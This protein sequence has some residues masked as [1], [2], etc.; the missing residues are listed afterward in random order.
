MKI[1]EGEVDLLRG[2]RYVLFYFIFEHIIHRKYQSFRR[3]IN[4]NVVL[5]S[6]TQQGP[7]LSI[8]DLNCC[9]QLKYHEEL[10]AEANSNLSEI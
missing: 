8:Y 1:A 2:E 10:H 7:M 9:F 5:H 4:D 6:I 3:G